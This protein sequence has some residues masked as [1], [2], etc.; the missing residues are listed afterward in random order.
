[1]AETK[2][3]WRNCGYVFYLVEGRGKRV[4][5]R[6]ENCRPLIVAAFLR[7]GFPDVEENRKRSVC[8]NA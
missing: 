6:G 3:L 5:I 7:A 2:S 8:M 4:S 1:M